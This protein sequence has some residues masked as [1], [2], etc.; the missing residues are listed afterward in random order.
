[1][2]LNETERFTT[3]DEKLTVNEKR[4]VITAENGVY[5]DAGKLVEKI[6]NRYVL[7]VDIMGVRSAMLHSVYKGANFIGKMQAALVNAA[8]IFGDDSVRVYPVMDGAYVVS[9][10]CDTILKFAQRLYARLANVFIQDKFE[11]RF[12]VRGGLAY[13]PICTGE[14]VT[15]EVN[16]ELSMSN[17]RHGL[18]FGIPMILAYNAAEEKASP[19]GICLD[20]SMRLNNKGLVGM[21]YGWERT[22]VDRQVLSSAIGEY[23]AWAE[24]NYEKISYNWNRLAEH[25]EK[26]RQY[27]GLKGT[28]AN[29]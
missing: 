25:A 4:C 9:S 17:Q 8:T 26:A 22:Y 2:D 5:F 13:G 7:F 27:W 6:D 23:F 12:L 20:V 21:W 29:N 19:F 18:L 3:M 15:E 16:M 24:N 1:M 11:H 14:M 10:N 28:T